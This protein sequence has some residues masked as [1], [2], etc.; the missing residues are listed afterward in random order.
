MTVPAKPLV[1]LCFA[2]LALATVVLAYRQI[3]VQQHA[4]S[5]DGWL[6][7]YDAGFVRR[8]LTGSLISR[9]PVPAPSAVFLLVTALSLVLIHAAWRLTLRA[10]PAPA[11]LLALASPAA[12]LFPFGDPEGAF[13]AELLFL[14]LFATMLW[15]QARGR[16]HLIPV[17]CLALPIC[18]LAHEITLALL[19][20]LLPLL[21]G[22]WRKP[23][24]HAALATTILAATAVILH[25][26]T[27]EQ[28]TSLCAGRSPA[29]AVNSPFSVL[30]E[31]VTDARAALAPL[32][33]DYFRQLPWILFLGL[34]PL[35][36][37]A[38]AARPTAA[39][40]AGLGLT[41]ASLC[42]LA[43]IAS[44]WGRFLS[45]FAVIATLQ[46]L[47]AAAPRPAAR[48]PLWLIAIATLLALSW[49]LGHYHDL[50]RPGPL[51]SL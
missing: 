45:A 42:A 43:A 23:L 28:V 22:H 19:P 41:A 12:F 32:L 27:A 3:I 36:P 49:Q 9:L 40:L 25:H 46:L 17:L 11:F 21:H 1:H 26:G 33:P 51:A 6:I 35:L 18:V 14:A 2:V 31:D 44:D 47:A 4:W 34:A 15:Q 37:A 7:S 13:R 20:A 29:C 24:L 30:G 8:G 16:G 38:W 10:G 48:L 5:L 39:Q 50:F